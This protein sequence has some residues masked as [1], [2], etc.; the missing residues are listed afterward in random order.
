MPKSTRKNAATEQRLKAI[1][2]DMAKAYAQLFAEVGSCQHELA[3]PVLILAKTQLATGMDYL[4][5]AREFLG[6]NAPFSPRNC[7]T[8][9][10]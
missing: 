4:Q 2:E 9:R 7:K 5:A 3:R 10:P 1:Q 6:A 8:T